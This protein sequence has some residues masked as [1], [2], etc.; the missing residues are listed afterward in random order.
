MMV[1]QKTAAII[2]IRSPCPED[3]RALK[4]AMRPELINRL[5]AILVFHPLTKKQVEQIFDNLIE[6]LRKRLATKHLG[7]KISDSAKAWLIDVGYDPKNGARPLRRDDAIVVH[8]GDGAR[9]G[10]EL[11]QVAGRRG[12]GRGGDRRR[13]ALRDPRRGRA[14]ADRGGRRPLHDRHKNSRRN[15]GVVS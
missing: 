13:V 4:K 5:D 2:P 1:R 12:H 6:D 11:E 9:R 3:E 10:G 15:A 8:A 14:Q 7:I